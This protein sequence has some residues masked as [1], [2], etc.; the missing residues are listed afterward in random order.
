M[1]NHVAVGAGSGALS[2]FATVLIFVGIPLV[3]LGAV[4]LA[5]SLPSL[6]SGPRYRPGLSW[7]AEP[8]W[9]GGPDDPAVAQVATDP[10]A[11]AD[12][13][14]VPGESG[15]GASARW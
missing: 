14:T 9:F 1:V 10:A 6:V 11:L 15:G 13:V 5:V 12:V 7:W 4:A 2:P 8:V 3:V